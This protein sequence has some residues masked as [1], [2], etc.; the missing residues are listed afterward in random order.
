M[1]LAVDGEISC[2]LAFHVGDLKPLEMFTEVFTYKRRGPGLDLRWQS[3][4]IV[5]SDMGPLGSIFTPDGFPIGPCFIRR[6]FCYRVSCLH[7]N[8]FF[9]NKISL[10]AGRPQPVVR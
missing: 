9:S 1:S 2:L 3:D 4:V 6:R 10:S 5:N 8:C 7:S